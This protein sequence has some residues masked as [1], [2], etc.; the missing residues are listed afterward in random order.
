MRKIV[1]IYLSNICVQ[2]FD[3]WQTK[4]FQDVLYF[5]RWKDDRM[6]WNMSHYNNLKVLRIPASKL[7]LPDIVLYNKYVTLSKSCL[8]TIT[9][10]LANSF[11]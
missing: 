10:K 4:Y 3:D 8:H 2:T 6:R 7:W 1:E 5:Q 11:L 9:A